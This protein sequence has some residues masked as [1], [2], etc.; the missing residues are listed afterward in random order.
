MCRP[1]KDCPTGCLLPFHSPHCNVVSCQKLGER[2]FTHSGPLVLLR[3]KMC[4]YDLSRGRLGA[5]LWPAL[6]VGR[7]LPR[8][9]YELWVVMTCPAPI[10]GQAMVLASGV[11]LGVESSSEKSCFQKGTVS[12]LSIGSEGREVGWPLK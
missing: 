3:E 1:T 5:W 12:S 8:G 11:V 7:G 9:T 10:H 6:L 2:V 4:M